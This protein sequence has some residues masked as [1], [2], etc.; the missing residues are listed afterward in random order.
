MDGVPR[1]CHAVAR[2]ATAAVLSLSV[3][4]AGCT[5]QRAIDMPP[6]A[7]RGALRS[8]SVAPVGQEV[9]IVTADG[10]E[11]AVEFVGV[12]AVADVVRG[13]AAGGEV[14]VPIGEV[15]AVRSQQ[16]ASGRTALIVVTAVA[17]IA[18]AAAF[19][20][21]TKGAAEDLVQC[22]FG[23]LLGQECPQ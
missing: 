20:R 7:L 23:A 22:T 18:L 12:D 10:T 13:R 11:H 1:C 6:D 16:A 3:L 15:V 9:V 4:V 21:G 14:L 5:T 17:V 19:A 8:G 2:A